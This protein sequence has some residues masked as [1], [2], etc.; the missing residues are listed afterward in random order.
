[1]AHTIPPRQQASANHDP[2]CHSPY[3]TGANLAGHVG[4]GINRKNTCG[5][6][7]ATGVLKDECRRAMTTLLL[8]VGD[9]TAAVMTVM[10]AKDKW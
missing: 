9:V 1:M 4:K 10:A 3:G 6:G 7:C 2:V 5:D 8:R